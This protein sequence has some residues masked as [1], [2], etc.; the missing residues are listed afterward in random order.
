[1]TSVINSESEFFKADDFRAAMLCSARNDV[2]YYLVSICLCN[3]YEKPMI[4]ATNGHV[5]LTIDE[6]KVADL[7][8]QG[9]HIIIAP[10]KID[11]S[12]HFINIEK[13]GDELIASLLDKSYGVIDKRFLKIIDA[14][15]PDISVTL[16][17]VNGMSHL[18]QGK[19][20][21]APKYLEKASMV[22]RS[23]PIILS[24]KGTD[25]AIKITSTTLPNYKML[26]MP[27]RL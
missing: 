1:M 18:E 4:V 7:V 9:E 16:N 27:V 19:I 24:F 2:R 6:P 25:S 8:A 11:K 17:S 3:S 10:F 12:C 22:F 23:E 21:I 14:C 15:Y 26:V 5:L 20:S 13:Q